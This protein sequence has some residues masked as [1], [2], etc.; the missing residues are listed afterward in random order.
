VLAILDK[1]LAGRVTAG[2]A[3]A[4]IPRSGIASIEWTSMFH[5]TLAV[6][7]DSSETT[8]HCELLAIGASA[9]NENQA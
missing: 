3:P 6:F 7:S 8:R 9:M 5:P 4:M 2:A 1:I